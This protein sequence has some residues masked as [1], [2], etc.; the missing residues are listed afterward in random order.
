MIPSARGV[1]NRIE[2]LCSDIEVLVNAACTGLKRF[3]DVVQ[4]GRS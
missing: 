4:A 3:S 1:T 2:F